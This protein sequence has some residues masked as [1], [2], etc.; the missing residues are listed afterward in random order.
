MSAQKKD[1][2]L[3]VAICV[4]GALMAMATN[5]IAG[6]IDTAT[7]RNQPALTGSVSV[8]QFAGTAS[9][10][11]AFL[12]AQGVGADGVGLGYA[13]SLNGAITANGGDVKRTLSLIR[14]KC[15]AAV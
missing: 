8:V 1:L 14:Q 6:D 3:A 15:E 9:N 4:S 2:L 11:A 7:M 13:V 5:S 12:G 10:C